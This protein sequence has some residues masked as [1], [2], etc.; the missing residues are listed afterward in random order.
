MKAAFSCEDVDLDTKMKILIGIYDKSPKIDPEVFD[1]VDAL[2]AQY[3]TEA[4]SH[5]IKGDYLLRA[6][7]V[8]EAL[9]SYREALTYDKNQYPIWNQV[10]LMEYQEGK[11]DWLYE[12]SKTCLEYFPSIPSVYLLSGVSAVQLKK[13]AEAIATL[14]MGKELV[15]GDK[16]LEAEILCNPA[17]AS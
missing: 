9:L 8:L 5:S 15:V 14:E 12:D 2:V 17:W 10:L 7:K 11:F 3:P 1:L 6:E 16:A 13:Y 4:K